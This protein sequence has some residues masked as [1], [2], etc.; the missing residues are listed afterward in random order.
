LTLMGTTA[1][2]VEAGAQA[3]II[4]YWRIDHAPPS[5]D[6]T[7]LLEI[8]DP[9][10]IPIARADAYI[11]GA[12]RWPVGAV[13]FQAQTVMIPPLT[14]PGEYALRM[15]WVSRQVDVYAPALYADGSLAG[16]WLNVG[17]L[18][19]DRPSQPVDLDALSL[20]DRDP[21]AV[22][23]GI[24]LLGW[25]TPSESV[26][27]GESL[28]YA[29]YWQALETDLP[30]RLEVVTRLSGASGDAVVLDRRMPLAYRYPPSQ[31][32]SGDVLIEYVR[33]TIPRTTAPGEY[34]LTLDLNGQTISLSRLTIAG[35]PRVFDPPMPSQ[36]LEVNF[37]GQ[38]AL[39]GYDRIIDDAGERLVLYWR[40]LRDMSGDY[41]LF[42]HRLDRDGAILDQ[43]DTMPLGG[44]YPT[45]LWVADEFVT[46]TVSFALDE[47]L[48]AY[49]IGWY[50]A[51]TGRRLPV[52][53]NPADS[54]VIPVE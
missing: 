43:V 32:Q 44:T 24:H 16:L 49:R 17:N 33:I 26:R 23:P 42:V 25:Q 36:T 6:F 3:R 45:T 15:T 47:R 53:G 37:D 52:S 20:S 22:A 40:A 11:I 4:S 13:L 35:L 18:H 51:D 38:I 48:H 9:A 28:I 1:P 39:I 19:I 10:G 29:L 54:I 2:R 50:N 27:P 41:T 14:P 31:W 8:I 21:I 34:A 46:E 30:R 12:E 5:T 7:P